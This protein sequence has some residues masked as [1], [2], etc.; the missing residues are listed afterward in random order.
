M[1]RGLIFTLLT[2][3]VSSAMAEDKPT[4]LIYQSPQEY[5]H[6]VRI[7]MMPYYARWV[8]KGP[9][10]NAAAL[11]AFGPHFAE[12]GR[13]DGAS[14][15]DVLV[16]L[17][18]SINYNPVSHSYYAKVT[19]QFHLGN[20]K[21]LGTLKATAEQPGSIQTVYADQLVRK[22]FD[23]AMQ[24]IARQYVADSAL[25]QSVAEARAGDMTKAPCAIIGAIPNP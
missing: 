3:T 7:G 8:L 13:C 12:V 2:L 23:T 6:E 9:S 5:T 10:V 11:A 22:A 16:W 18:P 25:Q 20:G 4:L 19:G 15:A 1:K 24:D 21:Y 17:R 14:G